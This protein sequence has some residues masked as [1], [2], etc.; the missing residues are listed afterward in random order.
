MMLIYY[1]KVLKMFK[2][3]YLGKLQYM[4]LLFTVSYLKAYFINMYLLLTVLYVSHWMLQASKKYQSIHNKFL[5]WNT[6]YTLYRTTA[7]YKLDNSCSLYKHT[8]VSNIQS[9]DRFIEDSQFQNLH[10]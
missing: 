10:I 5:Y 3:S 4:L 8:C 7:F 9:N 1:Y 2:L 6:S